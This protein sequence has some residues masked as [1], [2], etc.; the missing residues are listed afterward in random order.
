MIQ[1]YRTTRRTLAI[2]VLLSASLSSAQPSQSSTTPP[3][4]S[5][6]ATIPHDVSSLGLDAAQRALLEQEIEKREYKPAEQLLVDEANRDPTSIRA[7]RLLEAAGGIFFLDGQYLNSAIAWKKAEAIAPLDER[8]SFTLAM[9]YVKLGRQ[10]WA[11]QQMERL[12]TAKPDDVLYRYWLARFDYDAHNYASAITRLQTIVKI[13]PKMVRAYDLLGLCYDYLGQLDAAVKN[14]NRAIELNRL[15][16]KPSPRPHVDLAASL[17]AMNQLTDAENRL[18]EA[19]SYDAALPQAHYQLGRVLEMQ[20][21]Y[22]EAVQPLQQASTL[23]QT[24]AEPHYLLGR[25]YQ[26]L[27]DT[28]SAKLEIDRFQEIKKKQNSVK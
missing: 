22:S 20:G 17:I 27:G 14:Y 21:R 12:A 9:A 2:L 8:S 28:K 1:R 13:D 11:R 26:K 19:L 15:Q 10:D 3:A 18:R 4:D 24:Y 7:A 16:A 25:I 6:L 5:R 23:D